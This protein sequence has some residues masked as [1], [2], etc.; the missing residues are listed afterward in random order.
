MRR[1]GL[2]TLGYVKQITRSVRIRIQHLKQPVRETNVLGR[3]WQEI[4]YRLGVCGA[5]RQQSPHTTSIRICLCFSLIYFISNVG[6]FRLM[7]I[8]FRNHL[9]TLGHAVRLYSLACYSVDC[10]SAQADWK[11]D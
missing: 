4:E 7:H 1:D 6:F 3:V 11:L 10:V 2:V 5:T 9:M 8:T